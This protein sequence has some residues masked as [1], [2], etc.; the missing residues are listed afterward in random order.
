MEFKVG[1]LVKSKLPQHTE[2]TTWR[3]IDINETSRG[4][5]YFCEAAHDVSSRGFDSIK[6]E[7]KSS[8]IK[9]N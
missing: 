1:Q 6:H 8:E 9:E 5:R 4:N 2:L 3:V 7:F